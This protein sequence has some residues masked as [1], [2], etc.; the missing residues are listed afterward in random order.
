M[1]YYLA[2]DIGA[3]SGR[4]I[5]S[6][7]E[8]GKI[9]IEEVYRFEN[10]MKEKDGHKIWDVDYLFKQILN[11]MLKCKQINKIPKSL[12]IDTWA[13]DYALLDENNNLIHDVYAYRD[14]RTLL[15][16]NEVYKIISEDDLY[17]RTGIQKQ[18]FNTIYQLMA[19][20]E[21][22]DKAD[23]F[24]MIPDYFNFLLTG[25]KMQ[26]YT[27]CSTTQLLKPDTKTWD[28]KLIEM[29]A[30]PKKLF[31]K[32]SLPG[33]FVGK[34][35]KENE[36]YVGY[37]LD[38]LLCSSHDTASAVMAIPTDKDDQLYLSSGT[39]S[40]LGAELMNANCSYLSREHNFTNE[41]GYNYRFRF[42]KN[43]M[44][45]WMI[46]SIKKEVAKDI[47]FDELCKRASLESIKSIVDVNDKRFLAPLS[48][49]E[50][51]INYCAQTHQEIPDNPY[52]LAAVIYNSLAKCYGDT[53]KE[54]EEINN[55]TYKE[56]YVVGGGANAV[57]LNEL[58]AKYTNRRVYAGPSEATAIGNILAQ[59]LKDGV[60]KDL[61][62]A[63]RA[64]FN[65]FEIKKYEKEKTC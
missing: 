36:E 61:K 19:D 51:V 50:E 48:M 33:T 4:H 47:S 32:L 44:G 11:G 39:W 13:V 30:Y 20:K 40:L 64:V 31:N 38:V 3:S 18:N 22:L 16:D 55:K 42:L 12:A 29:L 57:Y 23:S 17:F 25:I 63:R 28:Y 45:L 14:S 15:M 62:E 59:L 6:H 37:N 53:I 46:Q 49:S 65:S 52:K 34:L 7:I 10:A 27:N 35:K 2:I 56:I 58:T 9:I 43:I 26:E 41:G 5:L 24:L 1:E 54:I 60:Y 21:I 8:N